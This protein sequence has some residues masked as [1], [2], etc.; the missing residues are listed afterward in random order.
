MVE[1]KLNCHA[2]YFAR[3]VCL[4]LTENGVDDTDADFSVLCDERVIV[5]VADVNTA[6]TISQVQ[7]AIENALPSNLLFNLAPAGNKG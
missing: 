4:S 5:D 3:I 2:F 6:S 1:S 7:A